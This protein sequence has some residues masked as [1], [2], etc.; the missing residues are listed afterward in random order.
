MLIYQLFY[1]YFSALLTSLSGTLGIVQDQISQKVTKSIIEPD[2]SFF[3]KNFDITRLQ[4]SKK[5]KKYHEIDFIINLK[6]LTLIS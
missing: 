2:L 6:N 3:H 5:I 4:Y 1:N